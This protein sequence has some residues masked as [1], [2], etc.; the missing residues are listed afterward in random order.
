MRNHRIAQ[1]LIAYASAPRR[2]VPGKTEQPAVERR[3]AVTRKIEAAS[4]LP[5]HPAPIL[6]ELDAE[7]AARLASLLDTWLLLGGRGL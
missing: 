7:S 6:N 1:V 2:P 3:Q 5:V 4:R